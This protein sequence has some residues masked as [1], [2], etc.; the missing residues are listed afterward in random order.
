M[1]MRMRRGNCEPAPE[2][3]LSRPRRRR[4]Q[5]KRSLACGNGG[6]PKIPLIPTAALPSVYGRRAKPC[7]RMS[8]MRSLRKTFNRPYRPLWRGVHYLS[9]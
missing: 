3:S 5:A 4:W 7:R 9:V 8:R 6:S 1:M 2:R